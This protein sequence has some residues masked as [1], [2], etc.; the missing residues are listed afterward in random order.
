MNTFIIILLRIKKMLNYSN[1]IINDKHK[2]WL[3]YNKLSCRYDAYLFIK[4][5]KI[6]KIIDDLNYKCNE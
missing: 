6:N 4:L 5:Y 1:N 3:Y 2:I